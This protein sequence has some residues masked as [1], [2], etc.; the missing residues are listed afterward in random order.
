[1]RGE[2]SRTSGA[3]PAIAIPSTNASAIRATRNS[4]TE[5]V[6]VIAKQHSAVTIISGIR[7]LTRP[8]MSTS[9][10]PMMEA[11]APDSA[12]APETAP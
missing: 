5:S 10:P 11:I 9:R 12:P 2:K 7:S 8:T 4:P 3:V 1:M 6:S